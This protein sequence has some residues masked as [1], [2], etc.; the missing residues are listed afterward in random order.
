MDFLRQ[1]KGGT[2]KKL[3]I[4]TLLKGGKLS[5]DSELLNKKSNAAHSYS[6]N[7]KNKHFIPIQAVRIKGSR[8]KDYFIDSADLELL[9]ANKASFDDLRAKYK[10]EV[11]NKRLLDDK[12]KYYKLRQKLIK[13]GVI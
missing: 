1:F 7:F 8:I 3:F 4:H 9:L 11:E 5:R 6:S 2:S 10:I 12:A 13:L